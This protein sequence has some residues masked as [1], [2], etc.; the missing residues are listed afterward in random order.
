MRTLQQGQV[1]ENFAV[2]FMVVVFLVASGA[3]CVVS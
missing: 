3:V 2:I 1:V